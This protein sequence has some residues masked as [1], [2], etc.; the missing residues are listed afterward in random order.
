MG[1]AMEGVRTALNLQ[2][3]LELIRS[4]RRHGK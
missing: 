1:Y 3:G 2:E 4:G